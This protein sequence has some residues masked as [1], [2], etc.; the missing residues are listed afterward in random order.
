MKHCRGRGRKETL[1]VWCGT[2][3][4]AHSDGQSGRRTKG[5]SR[6]ASARQSNLGVGTAQPAYNMDCRCLGAPGKK[7]HVEKQRAKK[8]EN[9]RG[10]RQQQVRGATPTAWQGQLRR[11]AYVVLLFRKYLSPLPSP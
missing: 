8:P 7:Q 3:S 1:A 10:E 6:K 4:S 11:G 5:E 9:V 2:W